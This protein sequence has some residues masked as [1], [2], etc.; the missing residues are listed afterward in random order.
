[1][2]KDRLL[3]VSATSS[4][5]IRVRT[6][7]IFEVALREPAA[8]GHRWRLTDA[9]AQVAL[10]EER[11]EAPAGGPTGSPGHRVAKLRA[12]SGGSF[13]LTFKLARPW[14]GEAAAEHHVELEAV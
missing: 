8:T 6:G 13:R 12:S 3:R 5:R 1:M 4:E 10:I 9:P 11:Y 2:A 14:E 7:D